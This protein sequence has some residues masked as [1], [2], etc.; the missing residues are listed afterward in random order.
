MF[1]NYYHINVLIILKLAGAPPVK[2]TS[3]P[4]DTVISL[5]M[6]LNI[7]PEHTISH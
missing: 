4:E 5:G 2:F 1:N 6:D 7:L 3:K